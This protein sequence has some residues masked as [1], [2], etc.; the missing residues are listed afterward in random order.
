MLARKEHAWYVV[1]CVCVC[2][3]ERER[4]RERESVCVCVCVRGRA[5]SVFFDLE[6]QKSSVCACAY[7]CED[8]CACRYV[9]E[10]LYVGGG[11]YVRMA[12]SLVCRPRAGMY[13]YVNVCACIRLRLASVRVLCPGLRLRFCMKLASTTL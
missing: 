2:V 8:T 12:W 11:L 7:V 1:V 3:C 6:L 13:A 4:E 9:C 10:L 5:V